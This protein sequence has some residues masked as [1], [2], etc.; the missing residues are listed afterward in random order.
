MGE[1]DRFYAEFEKRGES[2]L[3]IHEEYLVMQVHQI[4]YPYFP[5]VV[6]LQSVSQN[7]YQSNIYIYSEYTTHLNT[8]IQNYPGSRRID[9]TQKGLTESISANILNLSR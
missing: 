9:P 2:F 1:F 5:V 6:F 3:F 8:R 4:P 7:P